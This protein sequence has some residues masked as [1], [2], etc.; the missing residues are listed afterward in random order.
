MATETLL[1]S[2]AAQKEAGVYILLD[3][4]AKGEGSVPEE[5]D[6][7][8]LKMVLTEAGANLE[9]SRATVES[10]LLREKYKNRRDGLVLVWG[11]GALAEFEDWAKEVSELTCPKF[12][13][14]GN[15]SRSFGLKQMLAELTQVAIGGLAV[16]DFA[17]RTAKRAKFGVAYARNKGAAADDEKARLHEEYKALKGKSD[18][19][20]I[21]PGAT[22]AFSSALRSGSLRPV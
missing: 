20:N 3:R 5:F 18:L 2:E 6:L 12:T 21:P 15:E 17:R 13:N 16:E 14:Y 1:G 7:D 19:S 22:G 11:E 8:S 10:S 9:G 4:L